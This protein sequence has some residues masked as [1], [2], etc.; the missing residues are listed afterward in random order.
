MV[1]LLLIMSQESNCGGLH[2]SVPEKDHPM[3]AL[4]LHGTHETFDVGRQIGRA[5]RQPHSLH[6]DLLQG[7]PERLAELRVAI[8]PESAGSCQPSETGLTGLAKAWARA[9]LSVVCRPPEFLYPDG[10]VTLCWLGPAGEKKRKSLDDYE[11]VFADPTAEN[12]TLR[13]WFLSPYFF[14]LSL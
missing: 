3:E 9:A 11:L 14:G 6:A 7:D 10:V 1:S 2:C 8:H 5:R 13:C 4:V 12:A